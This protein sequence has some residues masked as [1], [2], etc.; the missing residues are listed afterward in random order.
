MYIGYDEIITGLCLIALVVTSGYAGYLYVLN[1]PRFYANVVDD[2]LDNLEKDGIIRLLKDK[3]G[4]IEILSG[5]KHDKNI[6]S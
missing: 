3:D 6:T 1:H 5:Y 2:V 4:E